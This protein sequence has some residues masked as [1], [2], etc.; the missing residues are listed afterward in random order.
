M[1]G[2]ADFNVPLAASEQMYQALKSLG[3]ATEL[4]I[5]PDQHHSLTR[6]SFQHDKRR[7]YLEWYERYLK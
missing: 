5:Y 6:V 4:I 2:A 1:C 7:R 3:V